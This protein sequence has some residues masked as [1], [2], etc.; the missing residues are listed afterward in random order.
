MQSYIYIR[1]PAALAKPTLMQYF[2]DIKK[3]EDLL[4]KKYNSVYYNTITDVDTGVETLYSVYCQGQTSVIYPSQDFIKSVKVPSILVEVANQFNLKLFPL[5]LGN[6]EIHAGFYI[7][8]DWS[9][10]FC[11]PY[12]TEL[13]Q[14]NSQFDMLSNSEYWAIRE[15]EL[16]RGNQGYV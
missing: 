9:I 12:G 5:K 6:K 7:T 10:I 8:G 3:F 11:V 16:E 13:P 14:I 2:M 4:T 15:K 1:I